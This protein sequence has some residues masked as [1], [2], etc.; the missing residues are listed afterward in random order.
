MSDD[1]GGAV[2][3]VARI[4]VEDRD[5]YRSEYMPTTFDRTTAHG[6]EVLVAGEAARG[7]E[8]DWMGNWTVV[9]EFP[10]EGDAYAFM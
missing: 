4:E 7:F 2:Y 1:D 5:T 6:G 9:I 3:I 10:S 8:G